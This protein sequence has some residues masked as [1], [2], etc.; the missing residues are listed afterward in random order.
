MQNWIA[1]A[2]TPAIAAAIKNQTLREKEDAQQL[3]KDLTDVAESKLE[4]VLEQT[5]GKAALDEVQGP[6]SHFRKALMLATQRSD[7]ARAL[8]KAERSP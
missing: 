5:L 2:R 6:N 4:V 7:D 8:L 3:A 1:K